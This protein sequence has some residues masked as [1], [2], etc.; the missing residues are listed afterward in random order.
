MQDREQLIGPRGK[1]MELR[2]QVGGQPPP[3]APPGEAEKTVD[4]RDRR[5]KGKLGAHRPEDICF[6]QEVGGKAFCKK[7]GWVKWNWELA[8]MVVKGL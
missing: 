6:L 7:T 2:T 5:W 1:G 8:M 3:G 4:D